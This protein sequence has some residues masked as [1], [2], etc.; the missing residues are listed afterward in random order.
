MTRIAT[1]TSATCRRS[2]SSSSP[3]SVVD[4]P[5]GTTANAANAAVAEM[6]GASAKRS[7]SAAFGR[8]S[9]LN[10]SLMPSAKGCSGPCQPPRAGRSR[11]CSSA[12]SRRSTHT[13]A[14]AEFS[15]MMKTKSVRTI[16]ATSKGVI[17]NKGNHE[18]TKTTKKHENNRSAFFVCLRELRDFVVALMRSHRVLRAPWGRERAAAFLDVCLVLVPEMLQRR[19][20]GRH[21]RVAEGAQGLAADVARDAREQIEVARLP[22]ATLDAAQ[23]LVEPVGAFSA[24]RALAARLVAVKVQQI[25]GEP[26]HARRVVEHHD[27]R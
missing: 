2:G 12:A 25:L 6:I 21:R 3:N 10:I 24:R 17:K 22:L 9:S 7:G 19:Q 16:C 27:R 11:C 23:D 5:K 15:S 18:G 4:A 8:S 1:L 26:D 20:H 13:I 14:A